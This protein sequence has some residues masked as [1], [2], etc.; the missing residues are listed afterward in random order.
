MIFILIII[1]AIFFVYFKFF[2]KRLKLPNVYLVTGGVK[3]GKS[4]ISVA[5]A[6][7]T[8]KKNVRIYYIKCFLAKVFKKN[9][10]EKPMLYS[11]IKLRNVAY[12][13]LTLPIIERTERIPYKS[14]VLID[15]ASL[16]ADSMSYKNEDLNEKVMLFVKLFGH[17]TRG[18]TCIINTQAL[19]DMHYGFKRCIS[20]YLWIY[21]KTKLPFITLFKVREMM[22]SDDNET[23]TNVVNSD[24]EDD[25]KLLW[26]FNKYYRYYDCFCYS[27]FTD[28]K[29]VKVDYSVKKNGKKSNLKTGYVLS[30]RKWRTIPYVLSF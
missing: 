23:S 25:T 17:S 28:N 16:L 21:C 22:Y 10:P 6:V 7:K 14:V 11:N 3:T 12:N 5:L 13:L 9:K 2:Y 30:F 24:V 15:E 8:Y 4:F 20:T 19:K 27:I 18:G 1:G 29:P 26:F